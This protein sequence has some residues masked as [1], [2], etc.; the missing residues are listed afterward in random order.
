MLLL[1]R[2]GESSAN[3]RGAFG[4][5]LDVPLTELGRVEARRVGERLAAARLQPELVHTSVLDR[6]VETARLV[7]ESARVD[8][9]S[10]TATWR[11]NERHYGELQGMSRGA[12]RA[13]FGAER[14]ARWRRTPDGAPP[15][16]TGPAYREQATDA[17]YDADARAIRAESLRQLHARLEPYWE[18]ELGPALAAS[19]RV[20][21]VAH[22]NTIRML[23][24]H[25]AGLGLEE[26]IALEIPTGR[27][28]RL[29][30]RLRP[31]APSRRSG[32]SAAGAHRP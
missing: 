14:V 17:R 7:L 31:S 1:L 23:L 26:A 6:A 8:D 4:G 20:L 21:V 22:G 25:A 15:P 30:A 27:L 19:R 32:R 5:W 2:H 13:R 18:Q 16:L 10:P 29:P 9:V 11:L 28:V 12:A 24:C 3:A